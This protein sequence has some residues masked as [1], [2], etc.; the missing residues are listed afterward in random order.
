MSSG[1]AI[2][3]VRHILLRQDAGYNAL[4]TMTARHLIAHLQILRFWAM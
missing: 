1:R 2:G 4:V 3:Q